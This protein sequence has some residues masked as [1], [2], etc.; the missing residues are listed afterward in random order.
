MLDLG[1]WIGSRDC[2]WVTSRDI[3]PLLVLFFENFVYFLWCVLEQLLVII[4]RKWW[5]NKNIG[6]GLE[7]R[8][9]SDCDPSSYIFH[10]SG[11]VFWSQ[12]QIKDQDAR[13][14]WETYDKLDRDGNTVSTLLDPRTENF[15]KL[16]I[17]VE[18]KVIIL[19]FTTMVDS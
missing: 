15:K 7:A 16:K 9:S 13:F 19:L 10:I 11:I 12:F 1:G 4:G 5:E 18:E 3:W 6:P 14:R 17:I 2:S 8:V